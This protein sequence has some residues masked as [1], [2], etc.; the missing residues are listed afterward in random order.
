MASKVNIAEANRM[1]REGKTLQQIGDRFGVTRE[2]IRQLVPP[3]PDR[4]C[5]ICG[6]TF[7]PYGAASHTCS[8]SCY[9]KLHY[10]KTK[11]A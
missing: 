4:V 2:R 10:R 3:L 1:R 11:A 8:P 5:K 9:W 7:T 6:K